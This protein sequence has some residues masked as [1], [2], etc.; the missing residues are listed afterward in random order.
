MQVQGAVFC[1]SKAWLSSYFALRFFRVRLLL[2]LILLRCG[3]NVF[4]A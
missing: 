1:P 3:M 4:G 2:M